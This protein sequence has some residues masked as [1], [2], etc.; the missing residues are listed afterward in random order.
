VERGERSRAHR[1]TAFERVYGAPYFD[2]LAGNP[3]AAATFN[4]AMAGGALLRAR[5]L[6]DY[7]W[8]E[9]RTVV[10]VGGGTGRLLASVLP[11]HPHLSGIV[12]DLPFSRA[13]AEA[14]IAASGLAE[15]LRFEEGSFFER[16]PAGAD[17]YVLRRS[18][19]TGT[20][21]T[22]RRFCAAAARPAATASACWCPRP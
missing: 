12:F 10:D 14:T 16:V 6:L 11:A 1:Q 13:E 8:S 20:T 21:R 15:R 2:W 3:E 18:C 17:A 7:D 5:L 9:V 19:T 4:R 22:R